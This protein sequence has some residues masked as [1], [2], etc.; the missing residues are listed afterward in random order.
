MVSVLARPPAPPAPAVDRRSSPDGRSPSL[1]PRYR[2]SSLLRDRPP[3]HAPP[4]YSAPSTFLRLGFFSTR[5]QRFTPSIRLSDP[6][7]T[8]S[9]IAFSVTFTTPAVVPAQ[10]TVVCNLPL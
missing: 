2:A 8:I 10:L 5:C 9:R 3:L 7:L 4:R 1:H 6:H